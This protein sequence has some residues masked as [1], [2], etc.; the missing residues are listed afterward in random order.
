MNGLRAVMKKDFSNII[1][2]L[3]PDI[4][5][6]QET[7]LQEDQRTDEMIHLHSYDSFWGYSTVKKGYSGVAAFTKPSPEH[8]NTFLTGPSLMMKAG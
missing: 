6:L 3:D 7:K 4:L 5:L 1:S 8:V 2:G